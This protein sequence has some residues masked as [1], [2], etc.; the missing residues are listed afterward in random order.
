MRLRKDL[1]NIFPKPSLLWSTSVLNLIPGR[2]ATY[3]KR[4]IRYSRVLSVPP[5]L[6]SEFTWAEWS[7]DSLSSSRFTAWNSSLVGSSP[8]AS[9]KLPLPCAG[10]CTAARHIGRDRGGL[11]PTA[12]YQRCG[13]LGVPIAC[14][15]GTERS[16]REEDHT[17]TAAVVRVMSW[18]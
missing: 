5:C 15:K 8:K 14:R 16:T 6:T 13:E 11:D 10:G 12:R 4:V 2:C 18:S 17:G 1:G 9:S 7:L 3:Q